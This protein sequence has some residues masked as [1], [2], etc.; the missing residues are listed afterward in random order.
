MF[1]S[2]DSVTFRLLLSLLQKVLLDLIE[3]KA[4]MQDYV[5]KCVPEGGSLQEHTY[6]NN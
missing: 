2:F 6:K 4:L 5:I 1:T 3:N